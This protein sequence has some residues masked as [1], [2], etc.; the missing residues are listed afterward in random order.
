MY[1]FDG[2]KRVRKENKVWGQKHIQPDVTPEKKKIS[3]LAF[4]QPHA[5]QVG[6]Q[7]SNVD[8][9]NRSLGP[10]RNCFNSCFMFPTFVK[11]LVPHNIYS[12]TRN[13]SYLVSNLWTC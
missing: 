6:T 12:S 3:S 11:Y 2:T 13:S 5:Q 1:V 7:S 10:K 8:E 9:V 4:D